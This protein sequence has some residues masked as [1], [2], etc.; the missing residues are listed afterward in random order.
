MDGF[1]PLQSF[2]PEVAARYDDNPRGDEVETV[3]LLEELA[4]GRPVC[5]FAIGTGG[6]PCPWPPAASTCPG[7]TSPRRCSIGSSNAATRFQWYA[8]T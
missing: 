2:G 4:A 6:S 1:D 5:E 7:S 3:D 8:A